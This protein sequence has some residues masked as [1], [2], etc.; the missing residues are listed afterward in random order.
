[1]EKAMVAVETG[2]EALYSNAK[3]GTRIPQVVGQILEGLVSAGSELAAQ[4]LLSAGKTTPRAAGRVFPD[5]ALE[6]GDLVINEIAGK[7]CGYW[8]QGHAPVCVGRR[9]QP[10]TERIFDASLAALHAGMEA[11]KPGISTHDLAQAVQQPILDAGYELNLMPLFKGIGLTIAEPPYSPT[12]VGLD[13][14]GTAPVQH[15]VEGQTIFFEPAAWDPDS[16][17]GIHVGEQ[18]VVT[19]AGCRR[20]GKRPLELKIT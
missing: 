11:L 2:I 12:G 19:S 20:L 5:R 17:V 1:M 9:P 16:N 3:A 15:I 6:E 4:V 13:A 7:Y 18:V 10:A 14:S 8:A